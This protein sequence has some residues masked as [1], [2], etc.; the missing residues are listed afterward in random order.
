[1]KSTRHPLDHLLPDGQ[2]FFDIP[3]VCRILGRCRSGIY[4]DLAAGRGPE[5]VKDGRRTKVSRKALLKRMKQKLRQQGDFRELRTRM[6]TR[7]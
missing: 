1:M 4:K 2:L 5:I 7:S 3:E 6:W